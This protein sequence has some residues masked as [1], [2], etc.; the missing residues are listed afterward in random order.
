[1]SPP[2]DD[3][4]MDRVAHDLRG[5]LAPMQT[6]VYLL[7]EPGIDAGQREELLAL[8]ERQIQRL[9]GM[10]AEFDDLGRARA[11]RL[12]GRRDTI[13]VASLLAEAVELLQAR[14]PQVTL[15]PDVRSSLAIQG[16]PQRLSQLFRILLG[17]QLARGAPAPVQARLEHA[18]GRLRMHCRM[19]CS[20]ASDALVAALLTSPHPDPPDDALG[21]G[22]VIAGAIA[23]AHDGRLDGHA[24]GVDT[25]ELVL[26][27]PAAVG[28]AD[29]PD[30][31]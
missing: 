21:L 15:A 29:A 1:M 26:E 16:D 6:A 9:G 25:L 19:H 2:L 18:G 11:G 24:A 10:I 27:L 31:P 3:A 23:R 28:P 30:L 20:G 8:L 12:L 13:E 22:L 4:W 5:P 14:P 7:R 17:Q